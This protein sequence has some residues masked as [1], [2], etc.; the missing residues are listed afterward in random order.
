[1]EILNNPG[2]ALQAIGL[3]TALH[4]NDQPEEVR[5]PLLEVMTGADSFMRII[6]TGEFIWAHRAELTDDA[7]G[8]GAQL[9]HYGGTWDL[10]FYKQGRGYAMA[11][12]LRRDVGETPPPGEE[13]PD[14]S[15]DPEA[16]PEWLPPVEPDPAPTPFPEE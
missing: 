2:E 15:E 3:F 16:R 14:P 1:M 7:K 12:A 13:W 5:A 11:R 4:L 8:L 6:N 9:A 10:H